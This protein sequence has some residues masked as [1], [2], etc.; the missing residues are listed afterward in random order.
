[1]PGSV[2]SIERAAAVLRLLAGGTGR[3]GCVEVANSLGLAKATAHGI[4]RTLK[5]VGFVEQDRPTGKYL[6]GAGLLALTVPRLDPNELRSLA[7]NWTD[8]LA[9]RSGETVRLGVL[10][11][12]AVLMAHHGFRP[13]D[14]PQVLEVGARRPAH[15]CAMGKVL[16]AYDAAAAALALGQPLPEYT[17][18][19]VCTPRALTATLAQVRRAGWAVEAEERAMGQAGLACPV[20]D[21]GGLTVAAVGITGSLERLCDTSRA[22]RPA[23]LALVQDAARAIERELAAGG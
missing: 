19:T 4:L 15:A 12:G 1:M 22:P 5:D 6:L 2:Q 18:W 21:R 11:R 20:R 13:D 23:L 14:S 8:S 16:L 17:P 9:A 7:L 3:L 10:D